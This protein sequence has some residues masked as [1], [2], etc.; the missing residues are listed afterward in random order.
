MTTLRTII[1]DDERLARQKVRT[2]LAAHP[3]IELIAECRNGAEAVETIRT[4]RP[5]LVFLDVQM[6]GLDGFDVLREVGAENVPSVV[7]VTA[8]DQYAVKAFDVHA[9]DYLLKPFDRKRFEI[10]LERARRELQ[11]GDHHACAEK[12]AALIRDLSGSYP[13]ADRLVVRSEGR[14]FFIR[15]EDID[16]IEGADNYARLHVKRDGH[17]IRETLGSLEARLDP[18]KFIRVHRS[19]IVN[20]DRIEEIKTLFHG[21]QTIV[22]RDGTEIHFGRKFRNRLDGLLR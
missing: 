11:Q 18:R 8:H 5:Q 17:L 9:I 22:L 13:H 4:E 19:A 20:V 16:W 21:E 3:D 6:P 1:V 10:S 7:F 12:I 14:I 15:T 2:M